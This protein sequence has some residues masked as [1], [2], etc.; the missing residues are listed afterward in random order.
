LWLCLAQIA[1]VSWIFGAPPSKPSGV[2]AFGGAPAGAGGGARAGALPKRPCL[3]FSP[4]S[5]CDSPVRPSISLTSSAVAC[6]VRPF[7]PVPSLN[8]PPPR[9]LCRGHP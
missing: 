9:A 7:L 8:P 1:L 3:R 2:G 5:C 4:F 6:L